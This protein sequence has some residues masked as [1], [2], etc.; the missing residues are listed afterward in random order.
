MKKIL[1]FVLVCLFATSVFAN[2]SSMC[3]CVET[4]EVY[5]PLLLDIGSVSGEYWGDFHSRLFGVSSEM[6]D[7]YPSYPWSVPGQTGWFCKE[8]HIPMFVS[9]W[10]TFHDDWVVDINLN[11]KICCGEKE[12]EFIRFSAYLGV[13]YEDVYAAW[14]MA[15]DGTWAF[16]MVYLKEGTV[17]ISMTNYVNE[18]TEAFYNYFTLVPVNLDYIPS[19]QPVYLE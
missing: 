19:P 12:E 16:Y 6:C 7:Y 9:G 15:P 5:Q 18:D 10:A 3:P 4:Y 8:C 17:Y 2:V 1:M 11:R 14:F 13:E